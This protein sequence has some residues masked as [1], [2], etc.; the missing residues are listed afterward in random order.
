MSLYTFTQGLP[1]PFGASLQSNG[2]NFAVFSEKAES[3]ELCLYDDLGQKELQK[4]PMVKG[5]NFCWH[6]LVEGIG[7]GTKYGYRAHGP[8]EPK[9]GLRFNANKLLIDPYARELDRDFCWAD[10]L[11]GYEVKDPQKDLSF[12]NLD[13]RSVIPKSVVTSRLSS[14]EIEAI[15]SRKPRIPWRE[16]VIYE[17]HVRGFSQL[18]LDVPSEHRGTISGLSHDSS[19]EY[20]KSLG[21]TAVELLPVHGF[22]DE[23]F[24][25]NQDLSNY[26]GY[27]SLNFFA[28]HSN[29][30]S[31]NRAGEFLEAVEKF[32]RAGLEVI[33][34]VVYNHTAESNQFG[35]TLS[36]RGL[37]NQAYYRLEAG[38]HQHYIND[39]GCGNTVRVDHPRVM[40]LI[41][42]SLRFWAGEM[43]VDGFRFDL[44]SILGRDEKGFS[45]RAAFFQAISQDPLLS[46]CKMIAE[47]WDI[48]PGG[49]QLGAYPGEWSEWNDKYRDICRRFWKNDDGVLAEFAR[50][51]HGSSDLFEHAGRRPRASINFITSHDG[52]TLRDMVSYRERNNLANKENN[53]DGHHANFSENYGE[54]GETKDK[55]ILAIRER[56][57]RNLMA[58]LILSQG[59]PMILG[60]DEFGRSQGGNN[61]AYCQDNEIN[62]FEWASRSASEENLRDFTA[63]VIGLRKSHKL[64]CSDAYIHQPEDLVKE[65]KCARWISASGKPMSNDDWHN[66]NKNTVGW[67]LESLISGKREVLLLLFNASNESIS[68]VL[69]EESGI[70]QWAMLLDTYVDNGVP[71]KKSISAKYSVPMEARTLKLLSATVE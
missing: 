4:I 47:P 35:P 52:F 55:K 27:N 51:I 54:E 3:I 23:E 48:G 61:N 29:Y 31:T 11:L 28:P 57:Q 7:V 20:F 62:W 65:Q 16:T 71:Q 42:D 17:A 34:D 8:F 53:R 25:V 2:V 32:H 38:D 9:S 46:Q 30:L 24:L 21:V 36:F 68:F 41:L 44:A 45:N 67:I 39:T 12:S 19:I 50:R 49:Y 22:I 69:P 63:Y 64:F 18:K 5:E 15:Q 37:D 66:K 56:Q 13:N 10:S 43:G 33:L 14:E 60:G 58:T 40:Q 70:N 26:W 1:A 59:T 6:I